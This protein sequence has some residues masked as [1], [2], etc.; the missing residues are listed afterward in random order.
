VT[1]WIGNIGYIKMI[2]GSV[3]SDEQVEKIV[4]KIRSRR[5]NPSSATN[6]FDRKNLKQR[7]RRKQVKL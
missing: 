5:L 7:R 3:L 4:A 1:K 6:R 2:D